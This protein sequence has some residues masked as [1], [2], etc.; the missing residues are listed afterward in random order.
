MAEQA[1]IHKLSC[2]VARERGYKQSLGSNAIRLKGIRRIKLH[3]LGLCNVMVFPVH[4]GGI[5]IITVLGSISCIGSTIA[6]NVSLA[7]RAALRAR[8][9]WVG[10]TILAVS[11]AQVGILWFVLDTVNSLDGV[12]DVG[13]VNKRAVP[14]DNMWLDHRFFN[15][16]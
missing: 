6:A 8:A 4:E 2:S 15:K 13:K 3:G 14:D 9:R 16:V 10:T 11:N 5:T 7:T 12:G 1:G